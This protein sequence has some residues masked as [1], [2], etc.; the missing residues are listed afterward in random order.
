LGF[1]KWVNDSNTMQEVDSAAPV[2]AELIGNIQTS[3]P[4]NTAN[5]WCIPKI[6]SLAKML[7]YMKPFGKAKNFSGQVGERVLKSI[8][9]DHSQQTQR[10]VNVF[11]S[12]C[13]KQQY[14]AFVHKYAFNNILDS[15]DA[16]YH[17]EDN[18]S[19]GVI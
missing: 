16:N 15:F 19:P 11:A 12:Q 18:C 2:L 5:G 14:E 7:H 10:H 4:R 17:R 6:H 3:F 9:K 1:E 13:A 8:V